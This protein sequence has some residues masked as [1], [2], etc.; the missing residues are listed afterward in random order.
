MPDNEPEQ[1]EAEGEPASRRAGFPVVGIGASAG[2]IE[3]LQRLLPAVTVGSGLAY[4]IVLHLAPER[5]S[6][7]ASILGRAGRIEVVQIADGMA[8]QPDRAYV[9]PPNELVRIQDGVLRLA[10]PPAGHASHNAIDEFLVSLAQDQGDNA[11]CA[12]L[13]GTGSDGTIGL[14][15]IKEGGGLTVAQ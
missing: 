6:F 13:S 9:I 15:A 8:V 3:A 4:V 7:L 12:I 2:G 5:E 1:V 10:D 14:R 11:A